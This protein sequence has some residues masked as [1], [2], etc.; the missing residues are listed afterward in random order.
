MEPRPGWVGTAG[1]GHTCSP[2]GE[3]LRPPR[4]P[5]FGFSHPGDHSVGSAHP[6]GCGG[7]NGSRTA[8]GG[9][10]Q[11]PETGVSFVLVTGSSAAFAA[12]L[13]TEQTA[14]TALGPRLYELQEQV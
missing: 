11:R 1:A 5:S 10:G 14:E 3:V 2:L 4:L 12:R 13:Q 7:R 9:E 8:R 6:P